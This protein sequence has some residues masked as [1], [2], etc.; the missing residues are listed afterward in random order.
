MVGQ[1][2]PRT[3]IATTATEHR[4]DTKTSWRFQKGESIQWNALAVN[5][6]YQQSVPVPTEHCWF[7]PELFINRLIVVMATW[8]LMPI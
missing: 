7:L 2:V 4:V 6:T 1:I 8:Q 5:S 3:D